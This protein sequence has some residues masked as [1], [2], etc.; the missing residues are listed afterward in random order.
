MKHIQ[1][2]T[3]AGIIDIEH[4]VQR[5]IV[6][7]RSD[8]KPGLQIAQS[9]HAISQFLLDYPDLGK[10]WNNNYFI[11]LSVN[12]EH[13]LQKILSQLFDMGISVSYFTEPDINDELTSVCFLESDKTK[14]ITSKL[15]VSL[16]KLN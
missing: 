6:I 14:R 4:Q 1:T 16:E 9:G 10:K 13:K 15:R 5:L 8:L 7:T 2:D 12:S 11:S 3:G